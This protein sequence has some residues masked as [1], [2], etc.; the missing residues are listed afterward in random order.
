MPKQF[1]LGPYQVLPLRARVDLWAMAMKMYSTFPKASVSLDCFV[2]YLGHP[3]GSGLTSLPRCSR[4]ILQPQSTGQYF[5]RVKWFQ[6]L[7][8]NTN[9]S[10][11]HYSF[12]CTQLN[13]SKFRK[14]LNI[15]ILLID[16]TL[17]GTI[18]PGQSR[19]GSN[20]NEEV[21]HVS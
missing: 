1:Y 17:T 12:V 21:L 13:G 18:T 20:S 19:P 11:Q 14:W 10:C 15:S 7:P 2:S 8:I 9:D 6:R 16:R 4:C 5:C 3:L